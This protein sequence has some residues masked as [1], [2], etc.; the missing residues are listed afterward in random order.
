MLY[1][2]ELREQIPVPD[3]PD[4]TLLLLFPSYVT[5]LAWAAIIKYYGL[6]T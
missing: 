6:V 3:T 2:T 1:N 5:V 4:W